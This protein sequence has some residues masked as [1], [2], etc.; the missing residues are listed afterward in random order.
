MGDQPSQAKKI[1]IAYLDELTGIYNR[2]FLNKFF[3][4]DFAKF[5]KLAM[6]MIDID[7][8]KNVND[9]RGHPEGDALLISFSDSVKEL[10]TDNGM[11][12][13]YGGDEF[14]VILPEKTEEEVMQIAEKIVREISSKP[15]KG[16]SGGLSHIITVSLGV[17]FYPEDAKKAQDLLD[18]SDEALYASKR[19]G[20]NRLTTC[21][22]ITEEVSALNKA[23]KKLSPPQFVDR[24]EGLALLEA[25]F[26]ENGG[27]KE[28]RRVRR[29]GHGLQR[30]AGRRGGR[31]HGP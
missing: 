10:V 23:V 15:L 8:F 18:K 6:F 19:S 27:G 22:Q 17:A 21:R 16:K 25:I 26:T 24:K 9:T 11:V 4:E 20:K 28:D 7:G 14:S 1:D 3:T 29:P 5:K 12:I 30:G 2:R 13:R 31:G